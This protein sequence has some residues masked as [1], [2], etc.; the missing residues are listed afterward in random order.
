MLTPLLFSMLAAD[1]SVTAQA[2][3]TPPLGGVVAPA[4]LGPGTIAVY[5][6]VGAPE[7]AAGYRQGFSAFEFEA[8]L[9]LNMFEVSS[10][11]EGGA[12]FG[13]LRRGPLQLAVG[14]MVG[15]KLNSGATYYDLGN[16]ASWA[17]RPV[18]LGVLSYELSDV[19]A[20]LARVDV[21][22]AISLN[23]K[24]VQFTPTIAM[25]GE[26]LLGQGVSL[27]VLGRIGLDARANPAGY[28]QNRVAW[29]LELGVGYRVF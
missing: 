4:A 26:V 29:G 19:V 27:L 9:S 21:P 16:F 11:L 23:V 8:R 18:A 3:P 7:L 10:V 20:A 2:F 5:G 15:L 6:Q 13:L 22:L 28:A 24:G 1:G 12:K 17:L 14:G 25:G